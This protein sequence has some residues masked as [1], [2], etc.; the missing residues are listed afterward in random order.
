MSSRLLLVQIVYWSLVGLV[1]NVEPDKSEH[2]L[3]DHQNRIVSPRWPYIEGQK[4]EFLI[5]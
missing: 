1:G 5:A 4:T 2:Q 3:M